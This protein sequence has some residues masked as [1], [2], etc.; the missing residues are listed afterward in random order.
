MLL[1]RHA[2]TPGNPSGLALVQPKFYEELSGHG[3]RLQYFE[4]LQA[5]PLEQQEKLLECD[6]VIF[7]MPSRGMIVCVDLRLHEILH[8]STSVDPAQLGGR[9][10]AEVR[11]I[12]DFLQIL[13]SVKLAL[14][15]E[16]LHHRQSW[17]SM[18]ITVN[19]I[20]AEDAD[21]F[22]CCGAYLFVN[23]SCIDRSSFDNGHAV[24]FRYWI[25]QCLISERCT[26]L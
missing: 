17:K 3:T 12:W 13:C 10:G 16:F 25:A 1:M 19:G 4:G 7:L 2:N 15:I 14:K 6:K 8:I 9:D 11:N 26:S 20:R 21:V 22:V 23:S 24:H 18:S 5:M